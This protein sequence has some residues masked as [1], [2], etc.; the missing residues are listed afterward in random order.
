MLTGAFALRCSLGYGR[1]YMR[2]VLEFP[3][4]EPAYRDLWPDYCRQLAAWWWVFQGVTE[5]TD[6][7]LATSIQPFLDL[8]DALITALHY[9]C[10]VCSG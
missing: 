7:L 2:L 6:R 3:V 8:T 5:A 9:H 10:R 1:T 4:H